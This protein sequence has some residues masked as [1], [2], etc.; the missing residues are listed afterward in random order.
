[1]F[2]RNCGKEIPEESSICPIC[3]INREGEY[4]EPESKEFHF[5]GVRVGRKGRI[6]EMHTDVRVEG[7]GEITVAFYPNKK[8]FHKRD[9]KS[10]ALPLVPVWGIS[11][12]IRLIAIGLLMPFT[13]G[14]ALLPFLVYV[15]IMMSRQ[16][17]IKLHS[18]KV[19]KIPIRQKAEASGF[20]REFNYSPAEIQKNDDGFIDEIKWLRRKK[21]TTVILDSMT[22]FLWLLLWW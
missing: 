7:R 12:W 5:V 6:I 19:I 22:V 1:M 2:C 20:L 18:G 21:W 11:G 4:A 17:R 16:I 14:L 8:Q 15:K 9:V 13:Y 10:I 3:G